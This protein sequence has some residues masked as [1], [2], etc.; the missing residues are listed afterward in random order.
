MRLTILSL[1]YFGM[2]VKGSSELSHLH[3][4]IALVGPDGCNYC[5]VHVTVCGSDGMICCKT[6]SLDNPYHDDWN[7][8]STNVFTGTVLG[9][10]NQFAIENA[11]VYKIIVEH[12]G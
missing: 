2:L 8:G 1:A 11:E 7:A 10:C 12:H 5:S 3:E 6:D 9:Q 4:I